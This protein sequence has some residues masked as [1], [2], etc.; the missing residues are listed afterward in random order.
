MGNSGTASGLDMSDPTS[1][2]GFSFLA[3][4]WD[5]S[6]GE[7]FAELE[8]DRNVGGNQEEGSFKL[9]HRPQSP[10]SRDSQGAPPAQVGRRVVL[11]G[12]SDL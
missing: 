2:T 1:L 11:R 9:Y 3:T 10:A 5:A 12:G 7:L 8:W 6:G 4:G